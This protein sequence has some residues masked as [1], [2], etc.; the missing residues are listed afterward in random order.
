[1]SFG[2]VERVR[3]FGIESTGASRQQAVWKFSF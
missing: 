3:Y 1:V 2:W